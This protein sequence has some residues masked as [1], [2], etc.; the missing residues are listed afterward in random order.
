MD[1]KTGFARCTP[2]DRPML[3]LPSAAALFTVE[4][5][6][7]HAGAWNRARGKGGGVK[8]LRKK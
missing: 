3:D 7:Y 5:L 4:A 1:P 6:F 2:V 8:R